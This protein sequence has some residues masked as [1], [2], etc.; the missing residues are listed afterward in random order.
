MPYND[1][2]INKYVD[3]IIP[4]KANATLSTPPWSSTRPIPQVRGMVREAD[5]YEKYYVPKVVSIGP[6]HYGKEK[7]Q[8]VQNL[9]PT[10]SEK[11]FEGK[12]ETVKS[13][14]KK[15]LEPEMMDY[16]RNFCEDDSMN[17]FSDM[18]FTYIMLLDSCFLL[19][20]ILFVFGGKPE[21]HG[22]LSNAGFVHGDLFLLENQIPFKVLT[23]VMK[24]VETDCSK[25]IKHF[26]YGKILASGKRKYSN[27]S[28]SI[29]FEFGGQYYHLLHLLYLVH[30]KEGIVSMKI[31]D[32]SSNDSHSASDLVNVGIFFKP[33][34]GLS[35]SSVEFSQGWLGNSAKVKLPPIKVN[36]S[37]KR[38]LLN[39]I[40][41]ETCFCES[42]VS[43]F[44]SYVCL[45]D[46]L[47]KEAEDIKVLKK[48]GVLEN[49]LGADD[50][51]V[52]F[53]NETATDLVPNNLAYWGLKCKIQR[54]YESWSNKF[55]SELTSEYYKN[56][57]KF[58]SLLGALIALFL[59]AV[60][61]YFTRWSPKGEC[62]DLCNS[63]K[64]HHL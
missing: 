41:F 54:H 64:N 46:S 59:S 42:V 21:Y 53:I 28:K 7:L 22:E 60:Q 12:R 29:N 15:L 16:L 45:L 10:F 49:M 50:E 36:D 14:Y 39:M 61:T 31:Y 19:Y 30:T 56:T 47:I 20:C 24:L 4:P 37:T 9:K 34:D 18:E 5:D 38:T 62:D 51:V 40:A 33:S 52:K 32:Y 11:I 27:W 13:L 26:I 63:L 3:L 6:Y 17:M 8:P 25:E 43:W 44:T 35:L 23:E 58:L 1:D 55:I 2:D 57:W 48:A